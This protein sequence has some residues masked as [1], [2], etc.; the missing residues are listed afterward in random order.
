T[1]LN[2]FAEFQHQ[3][4]GIGSPVVDQRRREDTAAMRALGVDFRWLDFPDAIYRGDLYLSDDEL[5]GPVNAAD[6]TLA[7]AVHDALSDLIQTSEA[8]RV[9]LPLAVGGH[10]D[11]RICREVAVSLVETGRQIWLYED[12]PYTLTDGAVE[13]ALGDATDRLSPD[14]VDV[15]STFEQRLAAIACYESQL[16]TIF[17]H[18]GEPDRLLRAYA[19][20]LSGQPDRFVERFWKPY[21]PFLAFS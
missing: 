5:F 9:Y 10:V 18:Y 15:T 12:L 2:R 13:V 3:R 7:L 14:L 8:A 20:R 21:S 1:E 6:R 11:H 4:W 19:S 17:R 16:P